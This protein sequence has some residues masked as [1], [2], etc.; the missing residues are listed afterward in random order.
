MIKPTTAWHCCI[1]I[2]V[3]LCRVFC[4]FFNLRLWIHCLHSGPFFFSTCITKAL[5]LCSPFT[6]QGILVTLF[7][8]LSLPSACCDSCG[9]FY[10]IIQVINGSLLGQVKVI[11]LQTNW[12]GFNKT[13]SN[14][15]FIILLT[16][17]IMVRKKEVNNH[18]NKKSSLM[19]SVY[20]SFIISFKYAK[21]VN[22]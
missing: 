6:L 15:S 14:M 22:N 10:Q 16:W 3:F 8:K 19:S 12:T 1:N 4:V 7:L 17:V 21:M 9:N 13:Y 5:I 11:K 2:D 20:F 18:I